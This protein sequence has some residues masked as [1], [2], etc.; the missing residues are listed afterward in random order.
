MNTKDWRALLKHLRKEFPV[1]QPARVIRRHDA[2][3]LGRT[4]FNGRTHLITIRS[5]QESAGQID[6]LLHEWS[7]VRAIEQAYTHDGPWSSMFGEIYTAWSNDFET[8]AD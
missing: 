7:H 5:N 2:Q 1:K 4:T 8:H 3:S 6:S